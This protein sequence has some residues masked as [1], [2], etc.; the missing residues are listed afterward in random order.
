VL[1]GCDFS[2]GESLQPNGPDQG[3]QATGQLDGDRV[4]ISRGAPTVVV[5][6]CDPEDGPDEDL[7]IE[8]RTIDGLEVTL[9]VENPG[10]LVAGTTVPVGRAT[11]VDGC[12]GVEGEVIA[13]LEVG[14]DDVIEVIGGSFDVARA[15]DRFIADFELRLPFNDSLRGSFDVA[16]RLPVENPSGVLRSADESDAPDSPD[17]SDGD[18]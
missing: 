4:A 9:V 7:C 15:D 16:E 11:C 2:G 5:G 14:E 3:I 8:A 18:G 12:D 17:A 1:A 13:R 10:A 6:D